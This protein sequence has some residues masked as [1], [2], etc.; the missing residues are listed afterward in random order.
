MILCRLAE[1]GAVGRTGRRIPPR[2]RSWSAPS[3]A[4]STTS[5][6]SRRSSD[7]S[8]PV[9][10]A[11]G[12]SSRR[13]GA[14]VASRWQRRRRTGWRCSPSSSA[15]SLG[16]RTWSIWSVSAW[17]I[18]A[19]GLPGLRREGST[20]WAKQADAGFKRS[21]AAERALRGIAGGR[22]NWTFS[23]SDEDGRATAPRSGRGDCFRSLSG[24]PSVPA[25]L[26]RLRRLWRSIAA[27]RRCGPVRL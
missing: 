22:R 2:S 6:V 7:S 17:S 10:A 5:L 21:N 13:A 27:Q 15:S 3:P 12:R 1:G 25:A 16:D 18:G 9:R 20:S 24:R 14:Q 23:G 19:A 11:A 8:G 26:V 4:C